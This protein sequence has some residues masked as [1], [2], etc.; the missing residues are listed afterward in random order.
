[1]LDLTL[2]YRLMDFQAWNDTSS[3]HPAGVAQFL[4]FE[5]SIEAK[6]AL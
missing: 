6:D 2:A 5:V 3:H 4:A 1:V